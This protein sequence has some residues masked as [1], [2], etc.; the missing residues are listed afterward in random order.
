[1]DSL[2]GVWMKMLF[3]GIM[4][5]GLVY[6]MGG[7]D[8]ACASVAVVS[9]LL[10][11]ILHILYRISDDV[12]LMGRKLARGRDESDQEEAGEDLGAWSRAIGI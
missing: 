7:P 1:M 3:V 6:V 8:W 2:Y 4:M 9:F 11:L 5:G 12:E 10:L